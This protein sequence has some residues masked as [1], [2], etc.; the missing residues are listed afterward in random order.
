M[1][2][3]KRRCRVKVLERLY[4]FGDVCKRVRWLKGKHYESVS[5]N[6]GREKE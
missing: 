2:D 5:E 4:I 1:F 6:A 3:D